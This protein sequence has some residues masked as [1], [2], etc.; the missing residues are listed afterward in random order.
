M[1]GVWVCSI[2]FCLSVNRTSCLCN[3]CKCNHP[4]DMYGALVCCRSNQ[5]GAW[6]ERIF[7]VYP[8]QWYTIVKNWWNDPDTGFDDCRNLMRHLM[9]LSLH[10]KF[11][12]HHLL[13]KNATSQWKKSLTSQVDLMLT[14]RG[15]T[16]P[17]VYK[18]LVPQPLTVKTH[19]SQAGADKR[20]RAV[21][22]GFP[23]AATKPKAARK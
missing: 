11:N 20:D 19:D 10:Q 13:D 15:N 22:Q 6:R 7:D 5:L 17:D 8:P 12:A 4:C 14:F 2:W 16:P 18:T 21:R 9:P 1:C 23:S 3:L